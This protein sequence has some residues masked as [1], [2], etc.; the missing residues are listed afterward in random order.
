[1][2]RPPGTRRASRELEIDRDELAVG[3]GGCHAEGDP[4]AACRVHECLS[5]ACH[6]LSFLI[7]K[8]RRS[9]RRPGARCPRWLSFVR[10]R[11]SRGAAVR[12]RVGRRPPGGRFGRRALPEEVDEQ[13]DP[14]GRNRLLLQ[15]GGEVLARHRRVADLPACRLRDLG[16]GV[17]ERQQA[18]AGQLVALAHMAV[19]GQR[20][21]GDVGDVVGVDERLGRVARRER[22]LPREQTVDEVALAEVLAEPG[23][24][25]SRHLG[26]AIPN[27]LRGALRFRLAA[28]GEV[29]EPR[30]AVRDGELRKGAESLLGA[31]K[32]VE[33]VLY[34][35]GPDALQHRRPCVPVVP[36]ERR[37]RRARAR[38]RR[39]PACR[40][41]LDHSAAGLARTAQDEDWLLLCHQ[42]LLDVFA[43]RPVCR[44]P[45]GLSMTLRFRFMLKRPPHWTI[46]ESARILE[47]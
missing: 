25:Q 39:D 16:D 47:R 36:V 18:G 15:P 32:G 6:V 30:N 21:D 42:V 43:F 27:C 23:R 38:A 31:R 2:C 10:S 26:A 33:V 8:R 45:G 20:G 14:V 17:G 24:G 11:G 37:F 46:Q 40:E 35:D 7:V 44:H 19:F 13:L 1:M 29:Y 4:F 22:E 41:P 28:A 12:V 3:L 34:V 5:S 9:E